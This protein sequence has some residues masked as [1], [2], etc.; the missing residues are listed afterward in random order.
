MKLRLRG[1]SVDTVVTF[2]PETYEEQIE[3]VTNELNRKTLSVSV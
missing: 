2:D 3:V 1:A